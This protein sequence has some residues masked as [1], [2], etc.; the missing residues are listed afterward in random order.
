MI[1]LAVAITT[2]ITITDSAAVEEDVVPGK[3]VLPLVHEMAWR[4]LVQA[5]RLSRNHSFLLLPV[6]QVLL[7]R[8]C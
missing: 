7:L 8:L 4:L 5:G 1:I 6:Q 2:I 3:G